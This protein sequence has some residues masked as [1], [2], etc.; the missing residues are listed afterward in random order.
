MTFRI[1]MSGMN[2]FLFHGRGI[3]LLQETEIMKT[4]KGIRQSTNSGIEIQK[5]FFKSSDAMKI[6][7]FGVPVIF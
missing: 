5:E 6:R 7:D 3:S 2:L 4:A 1:L